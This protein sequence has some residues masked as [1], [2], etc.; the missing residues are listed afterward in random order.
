MQSD[1]RISGIAILSLIF[2]TVFAAALLLRSR[3]EAT[4]ITILPPRPSATPAP[5]ATFEPIAVYVTGAVV[6]PQTSYTLPYGSRVAD[7][8]SAAGG[9][10][11]SGNAALINM[12]GILRDGDHIHAPALADRRGELPTPS[13]GKRIYINTATKAELE[14]LPRIGPATAQAILDHRAAFGPFTSLDD[15]DAVPRIG[16]TTIEGIADLISFD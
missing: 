14:T 15:L 2:V 8:I 11:A 3:P 4:V 7:A 6:K 12:A 1:T 5:T 9:L 13:G 16:P 10:T